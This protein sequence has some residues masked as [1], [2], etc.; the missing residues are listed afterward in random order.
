M[1][2]RSRRL[3]RGAGAAAV[4]ALLAG[5]L[6]AMPAAAAETLPEVTAQDTTT[7]PGVLVS[8]RAT[9]APEVTAS[10]DATASAGVLVSPDVTAS[11]DATA[12]PEAT[13]TVRSTPPTV[14]AAPPVADADKTRFGAAVAG[15]LTP[16][17]PTMSGN[18]V[19]DLTLTANAGSWGP[20]PV[21]L[22][23]RW[24]RGQFVIAGATGESYRLTADDVNEFI[25]VQV[26]GSKSGYDSLVK[27]SDAKLIAAGT[28]G[29]IPPTIAGFPATGSVLIASSGTW[30]PAPIEVTYQWFRSGEAVAGAT[31]STYRLTSADVGATMTVNATG[32]AAGYAPAHRSSASTP[33]VTKVSIRA[34]MDAKYGQPGV[35]DLLG[36]PTGSDIPLADGGAQRDHERGSIFWSEATDA[37]AVRGAMHAAYQGANSTS[38]SLGYPTSDEVGV[39]GGA[40]QQFQHGGIFWSPATGAHP[41]VNGPL[42]DLYFA[43]GFPAGFMGF[44]T[45]GE[46]GGLKDGG[47]YQ[48][49]QNGTILWSPASGAHLVFGGMRETYVRNRSENGSLGFPTGKETPVPGGAY[50]QFQNGGIFWSPSTGGQITLKGA[51]LDTY[52]SYGAHTGFLGFPTSNELSGLKDG[53]RYQ[54]FQNG[55]ILW[56]PASGAHLVFGGMRATYVGNG[57]ENGPLGYPTGR[58]TAVTGG[59]F[60]QFQNGGIYWSAATGGQVTLSGPILDTYKAH[61]AQAGFLGFPASG[62]MGGLRDNG[63]YQA[64]QNGAILWSP[65]SGAYLSFGGIREAYARSGLENGRLGYPT[66]NEYGIPGGGVR[67]DYQGGAITWT[68]DGGGVATFN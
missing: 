39:P 65:A 13:A 45:S 38:G 33:V 59:A 27:T 41:S 56:S 22:S 48:T 34:L 64:F 51:I 36:R 26:T 68:S 49:F 61:G 31:G 7:S 57:S 43:Y 42:R 14:T 54:T 3:T 6:S 21:N 23:Y 1:P 16:A 24:L 63:K 15:S 35:A 44:P 52:S 2:V 20:A 60:Q 17:V 18:P 19:M 28:I 9:A 62:V 29:S 66:S 5:S 58:E 67:Q 30:T 10:Q 47:R 4:A 53:G 32:T 37:V 8:P 40:Y 12:S 46:L 50:Q 55:T 25:R 11:Q